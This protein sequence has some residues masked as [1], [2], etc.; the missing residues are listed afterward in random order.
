MI[1]PKHVADWQR[2]QS[3]DEQDQL[4]GLWMEHEKWQTVLFG[5]VVQGELEQVGYACDVVF[6]IKVP[7]GNK[8]LHIEGPF[9]EFLPVE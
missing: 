1:Q 7:H 4:V 3:Y 8:T 5:Q 2:T 9:E 6:C